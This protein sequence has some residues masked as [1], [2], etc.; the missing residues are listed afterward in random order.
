MGKI[1]TR[2]LGYEDLEEQQKKEQKERAKE[3]KAQK[4]KKS[5]EAHQQE[6]VEEYSKKA[7]IEIPE[8]MKKTEQKEEPE[9]GTKKV[10]KSVRGKKYT[11]A[12]KKVDQKKQYTLDEA[13]SLLKKVKYT[14]FDG[15]F[16]LHINVEKKGLKGEVELPHATGKTVRVR[17]LDDATLE[18]IEQ[19]KIEFDILIAQPTQMAQLA[20]FAKVLGPK[21]LMPNPKA[22][23]VSP[24]PEEV[25]KKFE[26]GAIQWKT[27]PKFPLIHQQI[28]KTSADDA[29][30]TENAAV[31]L[32]SVGKGNMQQ[33]FI[34]TTM[35]PSLQID[36]N[37]LS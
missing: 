15:S 17:I 11:E 12:L 10:S 2:I 23:T 24:Q 32:Q 22:G 25:A 9:K 14:G 34:T 20:K 18:E 35:G 7:D 1:R 27:E 5:E 8:E 16:E 26:K 6:E 31:F 33:A 36:L 3:K 4:F 28:A 19:G 13:V 37:S 30:V 21:G 29:Q